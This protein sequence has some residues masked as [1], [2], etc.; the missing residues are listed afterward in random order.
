MAHLSKEA[1]LKF[2]IERGI[3]PEAGYAAAEETLDR[4]GNPGRSTF[5]GWINAGQFPKPSQL[6]ARR[7]GWWRPLLQY[8]ELTRPSA[9][10]LNKVR[11][12]AA[13][14]ARYSNNHA[15]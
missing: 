12:A 7:V 4:C 8:W 1:V 9:D 11:A 10:P 6:A 2:L 15:A 14:K 5:Y 3:A 13:I